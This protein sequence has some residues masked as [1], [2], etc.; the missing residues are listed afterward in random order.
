MRLNPQGRAAHLLRAWPSITLSQFQH[1]KAGEYLAGPALSRSRSVI[2]LG[3]RSALDPPSWTPAT[4]PQ[5]GRVVAPDQVVLEPEWHAEH[6][7]V[8][9]GDRF[10]GVLPSCAPYA[11]GLRRCLGRGVRC[12]AE[13]PVGAC[14]GWY[15]E[16]SCVPGG[17]PWHGPGMHM[18]CTWRVPDAACRGCPAPGPRAAG[19]VSRGGRVLCLM[20]R[21]VCYIGQGA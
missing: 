10:T 21:R 19:R 14:E 20:C 5:A 1:L 15:A 13:L 18:P 9:R 7:L 11:A 6:V 3:S 16:P 8:R 17:A 4:R 12:G 2:V